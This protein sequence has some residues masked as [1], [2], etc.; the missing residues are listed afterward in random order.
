MR[1]SKLIVFTAVAVSAIVGTSVASV[2]G[3]AARPY[4]KAPPAPVM[5]YNWTGCYVG[6]NLGGGWSSISQTKNGR[7]DGVPSPTADYGNRD[8][9]GAFIGG[10]QVGCD[11]QFA[12]N[13][14]VGVQG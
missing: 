11:Y 13:W 8:S 7:I 4:T 1:K 2:A 9:D 3:K 6:G 10:A 5:T 12:G 14:V